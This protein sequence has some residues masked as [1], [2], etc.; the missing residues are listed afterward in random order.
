MPGAASRLLR[1]QVVA[2]IRVVRDRG[3][4]RIVVHGPLCAP[5]LRRL[6]RACGPELESETI[7]L[8]IRLD[9]AEEVD[10]PARFFLEQL[11]KRG[12]VVI[13]RTWPDPPYGGRG[14]TK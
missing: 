2:K 8:E 11:R 14:S 10:E 1:V 3:T 12:A 13:G 7:A 4:C 5:D 9:P 6:E